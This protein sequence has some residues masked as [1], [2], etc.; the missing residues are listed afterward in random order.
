MNETEFFKI[1]C[2]KCGG[3]MVLL[4]GF[5]TCQG[6]GNV[7]VMEP[8]EFI[9]VTLSVLIAKQEPPEVVYAF[10]RTGLYKLRDGKSEYGPRELSALEEAYREFRELPWIAALARTLGQGRP[11]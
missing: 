1:T 8:Q 3:K 4:Q 7:H 10:L 11:K 6:C 2:R 5:M 9:S